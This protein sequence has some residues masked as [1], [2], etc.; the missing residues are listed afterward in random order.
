MKVGEYYNS[1]LFLVLVVSSRPIRKWPIFVFLQMR[2]I[3]VLLLKA[4]DF[5]ERV[6]ITWVFLHVGPCFFVSHRKNELDRFVVKVLQNFKTWP[7]LHIKMVIEGVL[8]IE[9][10]ILNSRTLRQLTHAYLRVS[11]PNI[12]MM[13]VR[14]NSANPLPLKFL[15]FCTDFSDKLKRNV[16]CSGSLQWQ[17]PTHVYAWLMS[18]HY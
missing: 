17:V 14:S 12:S 5:P 16:C 3:R 9:E 7:N 2:K 4:V 18:S 8:E 6:S 10:W 15:Q 1:L 13:L 11:P